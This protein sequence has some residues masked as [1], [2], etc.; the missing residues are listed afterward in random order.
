M[1]KIIIC[2]SSFIVLI[3]VSFLFY[4]NAFAAI[5][6]N[7]IKTPINTGQIKAL[8]VRVGYKDF[9]LDGSN[10]Y[11]TLANDDFIKS[12]F[13]GTDNNSD[14]PY[15]GARDY[16][17]KSSYGKMSLAL[18]DIVDIQ[19]DNDIDSYIFPYGLP[20]ND[21]DD[22]EIW[23]NNPSY[24]G[25]YYV[26]DSDEFER[27]LLNTINI[28][29]YDSNN[30]GII[31]ALY[32]LDTANR[33]SLFPGIT[34]FSTPLHHGNV[35]IPLYMNRDI[36]TLTKTFIHETGHLLLDLPD[37]YDLN[38]F[39]TYHYPN[40]S[41]ENIMNTGYGDYDAVAKWHMG[42][43]NDDNVIHIFPNNNEIA[44]VSLTPSDSDN[45]KG[46]KLVFINLKD[47]AYIDDIDEELE[48]YYNIAVEYIS[49]SNNN[50]FSNLIKPK[51]FR[52]YLLEDYD[53]ESGIPSEYS[54]IN[55][56][57]KTGKYDPSFLQHISYQV[58]DE[59]DTIENLFDLGIDITE[60]NAGDNPSFTYH[61]TKKNNIDLPVT[62]IYTSADYTALFEQ[63]SRLSDEFKDIDFIPAF[64]PEEYYNKYTEESLKRL[65]EALYTQ[66]DN[67]KLPEQ[68]I[69]DQ[70]T[71]KL[72]AAIDGLELKPLETEKETDVTEPTTT[73][74][75]I[76][77]E[78]SEEK[79]EE[80]VS[81]DDIIAKHIPNETS[82]AEKL[83]FNNIPQ[84]KQ[85]SAASIVKTIAP[86]TGDQNNFVIP[87]AVI[88]ISG[89]A[90][91]LLSVRKRIKR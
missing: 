82:Q 80:P 22:Y 27:K 90:I 73:T 84:R 49:G 35:W 71:E 18:G 16:I 58:L 72:K 63:I 33:R 36:K 74:V 37:Y 6:P 41:V 5:T 68:Y 31:D 3:G 30:D 59:E 45:D 78:H 86:Q 79:N 87:L 39:D 26:I 83:S 50:H 1:K 11:Y 62:D 91:I 75:L 21:F 57:Y 17:E 38:G 20:E 28:S 15:N 34:N 10:E 56:A 66:Y 55:R 54:H 32:I 85:K 44:T 69:V 65:E 24:R 89:S 2:L 76:E 7:F 4:T 43:L 46:K 61:Y 51:G 81:N 48:K 64:L 77:N 9:P 8:V 70:N 52:F 12:I 19:M 25:P 13:E 40:Y 60:I 23:I 47:Y 42:W 53:Y 88:I 14:L 67:Y 29:D